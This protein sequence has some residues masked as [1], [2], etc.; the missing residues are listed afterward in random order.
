MKKPLIM[1][2]EARDFRHYFTK[3]NPSNLIDMSLTKKK[4]RR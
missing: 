1:Y 2:D 3:P 4:S